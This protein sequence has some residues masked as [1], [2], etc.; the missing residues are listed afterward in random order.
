VLSLIPSLALSYPYLFSCHPYIIVHFVRCFITC[1]MSGK[2]M[3]F[4][5]CFLTRSCSVLTETAI[6]LLLETEKLYDAH[7]MVEK[8]IPVYVHT[9]ILEFHEYWCYYSWVKKKD[10]EWSSFSLFWHLS[11]C[12]LRQAC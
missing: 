7:T 4:I 3:P 10:D 12:Y 5:F 6:N 8:D 11:G 1:S 9:C 2:K